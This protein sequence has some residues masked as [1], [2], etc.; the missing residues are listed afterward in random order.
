[1]ALQP[2][3]QLW[4]SAPQHPR[5]PSSCALRHSLAVTARKC[6]PRRPFHVISVSFPFTKR[7]RKWEEGTPS[8][9]VRP[10]VHMASELGT[11]TSKGLFV[12]SPE[13]HME[14]TQMR[15]S[16]VAGGL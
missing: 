14:V 5:V 13:V 10:G 1:M 6:R 15:C 3:L 7:K 8:T 4:G 16:D 9:S 11:H 2:L 12:S